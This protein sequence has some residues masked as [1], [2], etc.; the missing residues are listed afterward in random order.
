VLVFSAGLGL[1]YLVLNPRTRG[2]G[3]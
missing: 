1:Y 2:W 3:G